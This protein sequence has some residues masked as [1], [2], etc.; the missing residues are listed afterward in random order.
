MIRGIELYF[1][2]WVSVY[3]GI[4]LFRSLSRKEKW[5]MAK[6]M[7]FGGVTALIALIIVVLI[8]Y[9]F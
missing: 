3:F 1:A 4:V 9:L 2:L 6:V 5:K 7:L 8:V